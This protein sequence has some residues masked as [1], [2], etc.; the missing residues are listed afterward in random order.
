MTVSLKTFVL[1]T[2]ILIGGIFV[3]SGLS[4][5]ENVPLFLSQIY[6]YEFVGPQTGVLIAA[7]LPWIELTLGGFLIGGALLRGALWL[8][9]LLFVAFT[10]IRYSALH[11]DLDI[12]CGCFGTSSTESIDSSSFLQTSGLLVLC[13]T[14]ACLSTFASKR[15]FSK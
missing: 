10:A 3:L 6:A 15:L 8:S 12:S 2:R 14:A 11:R 5:I 7:T 13:L 4:K 1:L 9:T